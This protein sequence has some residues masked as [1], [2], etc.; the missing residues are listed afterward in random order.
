MAVFAVTY[1]L[2]TVALGIPEAT[3]LLGRV[4]RLARR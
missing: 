1:G 4:R 3:A 2:M